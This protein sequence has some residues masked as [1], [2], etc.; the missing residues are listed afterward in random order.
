MNNIS[1]NGNPAQVMNHESSSVNHYRDVNALRSSE[2]AIEPDP[3]PGEVDQLL[4]APS[5]QLSSNGNEIPSYWSVRFSIVGV[6]SSRNNKELVLR[7]LESGELVGLDLASPS[8]NASTLAIF[9]GNP[10][11]SGKSLACVVRDLAQGAP[12]LDRLVQLGP[13]IHVLDDISLV[14]FVSGQRLI[15]WKPDKG[16]TAASTPILG[17]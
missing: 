15:I 1:V 7:H 4:R 3:G 17:E 6:R 8:K 11:W 13:G 14:A 16:F 10:P 5:S 12:N 2:H 9:V